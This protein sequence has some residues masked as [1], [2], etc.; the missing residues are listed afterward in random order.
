MTF[1]APFALSSSRCR[2][3]QHP[4]S[5]QHRNLDLIQFSQTDFTSGAGE[6]IEAE[7]GWLTVPESRQKP[8]WRRHPIADRAHSRAHLAHR[9]HL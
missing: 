7:S 2:R 4:T 1:V 8:R 5:V 6:E 9:V 3:W